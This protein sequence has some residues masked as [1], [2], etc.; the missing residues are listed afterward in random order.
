MVPILEAVHHS[1]RARATFGIL[2]DLILVVPF[3]Q[4]VAVDA[5]LNHQASLR[6]SHAR[7]LATNE[8]R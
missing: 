5:V 3:S 8:C 7:S 2:L 1:C 4:H 6:A